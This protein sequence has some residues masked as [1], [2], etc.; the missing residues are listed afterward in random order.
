MTDLIMQRPPSSPT[1]GYAF[2]VLVSLFAAG[3]S[4]LA[5]AQ[6]MLHWKDVWVRSMPPGAQV[7]AAYGMLMNHSDQ[8][9]TLSTVSSEISGS[10]EMHEVIAEGDQY[11]MAELESIDIAPHETLIFEAGGRHIML[12]DIAA[13]PIEGENVEI[14]AVSAAGTRAC[15]EAAVRRQAP[16]ADDTHTGH[17]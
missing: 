4:S 14:C 2:T 8:T 5:Y 3:L 9:V 12:L 7:S 15:T 1:Q 13:P 16:V 6:E 11:R 17:H 10:A